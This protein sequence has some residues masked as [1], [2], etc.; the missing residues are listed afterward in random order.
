MQKFTWD[1]HDS[2]VS[3]VEFISSDCE[4]KEDVKANQ[5]SNPGALKRSQMFKMHEMNFLPKTKRREK[6]V[7]IGKA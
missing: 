7:R 4:R 2:F 1:S 3:T 5:L 6:Y